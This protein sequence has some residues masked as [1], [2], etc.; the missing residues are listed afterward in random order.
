L[1][2]HR[3]KKG[4]RI[5]FLEYLASQGLKSA[6]WDRQV[7]YE[8][9]DYYGGAYRPEG[10]EAEKKAFWIQF[11]KRLFDR[12]RVSGS[13][14]SQSEMHWAAIRDVFGSGCFELYADVRPALGRLRRR[15]FRL[16]VV[17]NW[18]KGLDL[19]CREMNLSGLLDAVVSSAEIGIEKPHPRIFDEAVRRLR[20]PPEC[21]VHVGD[22]PNDDVNGAISAGLKAVLIDRKDVYSAHPNR[23]SNLCQLESLLSLD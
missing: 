17:S 9:F 14:A 10:S 5:L 1:A 16:A 23:I 11:T 18:H 13:G 19:F 8:V 12:F 15:E 2:D 6:P 7:L 4:R 22:S 3:R 20:V 21:V